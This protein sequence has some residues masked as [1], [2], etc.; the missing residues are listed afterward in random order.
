MFFFADQATLQM[1]V[2]NY[3]EAMAKSG[4]LLHHMSLN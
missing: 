1:L 2:D 3:K 4:I